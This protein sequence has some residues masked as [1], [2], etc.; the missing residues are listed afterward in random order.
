MLAPRTAATQAE[1][2]KKNQRALTAI[3]LSIETDQLYI[4]E[5][6]ET[7]AEAWQCLKD[8]FECS[9][10]AN[11]IFLRNEYIRMQMGENQGMEDHIVNSH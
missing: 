6:C 7:A 3:I 4:V 8:H 2:K 9:S 10:L 5:S 11:Q 1:F